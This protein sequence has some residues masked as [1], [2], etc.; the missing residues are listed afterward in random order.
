MSYI[1]ISRYVDGWY[2]C[3]PYVDLYEIYDK[4]EIKNEYLNIL[5][6]SIFAKKQDSN[7]TGVWYLLIGNILEFVKIYGDGI[8]FKKLFSIFKKFL[9]VSLIYSG[10]K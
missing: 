1:E 2:S 5:H 7:Y 6:N 4:D 8:D 9:D 3:L 10:E